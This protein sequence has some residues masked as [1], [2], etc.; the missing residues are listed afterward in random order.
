[1]KD[2]NN[3]GSTVDY[4]NGPGIDNK[5]R[6]IST[7]RKKSTAL[8]YETDHLGSTSALTNEK[9][10]VA[11]EV[12]YDA[13]G[14]GT[15][16][17]ETRYD[18]TGRERDPL[19]GLLFYRA[20]WYDPQIGRF[21]SE[22]PTGLQ[23][24]VNPFAYVEN[25]PLSYRDPQGQ[26]PSVGPLKVH[27]A[28]VKRVLGNKVT[29]EE[30]RILMQEQEDFD[31]NTQD[32]VYAYMHAMRMRGESREDARRK[33]NRFIRQQICIAR[34]LAA[35]G[36]IADAMHNLAQAIHTLQDS[37]SPAHANFAVAWAPTLGQMINH[38]PHDYDEFFDP[39]GG[40][41]A[42]ELTLAAWHYFK[43]ELPMPSD[44]FLDA[45]DL[46]KY[47]RGYFRGT[48]APDGGGCNCK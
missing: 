23:G 41:V 15:G 13:F 3:D 7:V 12:T 11:D 27:Q 48:P 46:N 34:R 26:W 42:D 29:P 9:G 8:Y 21:I 31:K 4:L 16:S 36:Q 44:F 35:A 10:H 14:N 39:G 33:A 30:L 22:D 5:V 25:N 24:G 28:I 37:A 38:I 43:G 47:G 2:V 32:E 17:K 1:M 19:T 40:S 20:R 6:Q 45:F 18:Y